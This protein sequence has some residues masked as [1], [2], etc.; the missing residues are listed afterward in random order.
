MET[1]GFLTCQ[2]GIKVQIIL[3]STMRAFVSLTLCILFGLNNLPCE[4]ITSNFRMG[5]KINRTRMNIVVFAA[6]IVN[7]NV[8]RKATRDYDMT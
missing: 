5:G 8:C 2:H 1:L 6:N 3:R 4:K 7:S